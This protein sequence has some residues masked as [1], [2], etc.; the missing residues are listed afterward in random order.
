MPA[1][2]AVALS[3]VEALLA[4]AAARARVAVAM[5][6]MAVRCHLEPA[7]HH[8]ANRETLLVDQEAAG[9]VARVAAAVTVARMVTENRTANEAAGSMVVKIHQVKAVGVCR[10]RSR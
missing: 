1:A 2:R 7:A 3:L 4:T 5:A 8:Y 9:I 6:W 10:R